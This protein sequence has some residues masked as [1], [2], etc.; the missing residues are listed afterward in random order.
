M[1]ESFNLL[2]FVSTSVFSTSLLFDRKALVAS[3]Y[4][5]FSE[6]IR[7]FHTAEMRVLSTV[8]GSALAMASIVS[9][10]SILI[11]LYVWPEDITTWDP[12]YNT[13]SENPDIEFQVII[14]PNSGPGDS[15]KTR[16]SESGYRNP[17]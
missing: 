3:N 7:S 4:S 14:N 6:V 15:S 5:F 2:C 13:A 17:C 11:P 9:S 12:V 10:T 16:G 1:M 8:M